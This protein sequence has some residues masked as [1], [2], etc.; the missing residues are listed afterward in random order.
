[1]VAGDGVARTLLVIGL[2]VG[3]IW[4]WGGLGR[5]EAARAWSITESADTLKVIYGGV[6]ICELV[7][8][9][10]QSPCFN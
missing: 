1:M 6:F 7:M 3:N 8:Q 10:Q 2:A 4:G 9:Q 5:G